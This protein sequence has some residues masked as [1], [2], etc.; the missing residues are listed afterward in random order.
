MSLTQRSVRSL[1]GIAAAGAVAL[2]TAGASA[3]PTSLTLT[4]DGVHFIDSSVAGGM[5][6]RGRFTAA[7]PLCPAGTAIDVQDIEVEPLT[8]LRRHTCDDGSG[9]FTS[10]LPTVRNEHGGLGSWKIVVGTG[11]YETLRGV[12]TYTGRLVSGD[13]NVFETIVY[14]T[15]WQGLVDFDAVAPTLT[16][17]ARSKKLRRPARTYTIQTAIDGHEPNIAYSVD[18][19]AGKSYLAL[20]T[21]ASNSG[22]AI[23]PLRIRAARLVRSVNVIVTIADAV[24]NES[25]RTLAVKLK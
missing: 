24:G 2:G 22:R 7:P 3:A 18:I 13:P 1:V 17:T 5:N 20:K 19:R 4:F 12:G 21:G 25:T 10:F 8:V 6:H 9:T 16:A 23:V 14:R 15:S 11:R